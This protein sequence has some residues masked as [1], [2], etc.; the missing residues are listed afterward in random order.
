MAQPGN[1]A[2]TLLT[3]VSGS[4]AVTKT[5][6]VFAGAAIP[7]VLSWGPNVSSTIKISTSSRTTASSCER[8]RA[9]DLRKA[10]TLHKLKFKLKF[11]LLLKIKN[12]F[13]SPP[14]GT[15]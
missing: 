7:T 11:S 8:S 14:W 1:S 2:F 15:D 4:V 3:T 9:P 5:N 13:N 6:W 12:I 10:A